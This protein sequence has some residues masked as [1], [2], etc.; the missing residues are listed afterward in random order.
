MAKPIGI[1]LLSSMALLACTE[2]KSP[3][4]PIE[5][6]AVVVQSAAPD[7]D[8]R[9]QQLSQEYFALRPEVASY[10]G[11]PDEKAGSGISSR[12]GNY[13][14][15]GETRRREGLKA[16]LDG[17]AG[18]DKTLL[19]AS[20]KISLELVET[21]AG[22][23]YV[24]ATLVDYGSVLGEY[25]VWFIPYVVSH[26]T[27]PHVE[28]PAIL[29]DK[30]AIQ[31]KADAMAYLSR[32][33]R[34]AGVLDEVIE[35]M[36]YDRELGVVPPDFSIDKA[37]ANLAITV[38][39]PAAENSLVTGFGRKLAAADIERPDEFIEQA[40]ALV[41]D[42]VYP[43][44]TRLIE[45]LAAL[46]LLA[47]HEPGVGRLPNGEA[48]YRAMI[49]HMTDTTLPADEI[50]AIGLV[51][52]ERI[53]REMDQLLITIGYTEG[54]VGA[55]M[56]EM[57]QDPEYIYPDT[58]EGKA[59]LMADLAADLAL[60]DAKLPEWF[61][62]LPDQ[63]VAIKAV[64][65]HREASTSGAFYDAPSMDGSRPG[66]VWISL[67]DTALLPSY[68]LQTLTYH[69]ANPGHH[70]Q[71][72]LSLDPSLPILSSIFYSNAAGEGW[73]LYAEYLASEMGLY[74]NDPVDDL[75]RLQQELHRAVRLVV[76]T[77]MHALGWSRERAIEYSVATEGIHLDE[78][79]AEV[80]R[81]AVWPGQ[82]LGY[83]LGMLKILE[84]RKRAQQQLG[85]RFD[86][87]TF[88]DRVLEE[89]ALPLN[90]MEVKIDAWIAEQLQDS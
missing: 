54:T 56:S 75:G 83:K 62:N 16:I 4:Q 51:E 39:M 72:I 47:S 69:E 43:A 87:R 34:Y 19:T 2:D 48:F 84:L 44:T 40:V 7:F 35:K 65:P 66:T 77:G 81:Y 23:A 86:I 15:A 71:T 61:G 50:H 28:I 73:G 18:I 25:G 76:D 58:D 3:V 85:D 46:R 60:A 29:E 89:G 80:E 9:M 31:N 21:E 11:V 8:A 53:H 67:A 64:P 32:L 79:T 33:N 41:N 17:L 12:L 22:N 45:A 20:Q 57:L 70:L 37:I 74:E 52:V 38:D 42:K 68:S 30:M 82:A 24:P 49:T 78:A 14:P 36:H 90:L 26:L 5:K 27:G 6:P 63:E 1:A 10:F 13:S 88:H 55:R 59:R